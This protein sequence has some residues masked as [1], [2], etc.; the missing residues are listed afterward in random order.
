MHAG[1]AALHVRL[2]YGDLPAARGRGLIPV[3]QKPH[4]LPIKSNKSLTGPRACMHARRL[5]ALRKLVPHAERANTA[6]FLE[7]VIK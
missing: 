1:V 7:E 2:L 5:D 4:V 3:H 6:C